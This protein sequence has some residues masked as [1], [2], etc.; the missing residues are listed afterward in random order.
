MGRDALLP[1]SSEARGRLFRKLVKGE[2]QLED[3]HTRFAEQSEGA[4]CDV[5]LDEL[6]NLLFR[7]TAGLRDAGR[8]EQGIVRSDVG[9]EAG[10]GGGDRIDRYRVAWILGCEFV[11]VTLNTLHQFGIRLSKVGTA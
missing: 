8:L 5:L 9:V 7:E 4:A 1:Y 6:A 10:A 3:V 11:Y 2:V